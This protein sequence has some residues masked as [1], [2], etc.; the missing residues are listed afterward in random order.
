MAL[1]RRLSFE[2]SCARTLVAPV[3]TSH[4]EQRCCVALPSATSSSPPAESTKRLEHEIL[5]LNGFSKSY[6]QVKWIFQSIM[7]PIKSLNFL[8]THSHAKLAP[9]SHVN[10]G[11]RQSIACSDHAS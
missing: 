8:K 7:A 9:D 5:K 6:C 2:P 1:P 11:F 10:C 3:R 4:L